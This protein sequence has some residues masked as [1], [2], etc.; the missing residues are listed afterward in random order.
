MRKMKKL[1]YCIFVG[2]ILL[3]G[4]KFLTSTHQDF[5]NGSVGEKIICFG[6]SLTHGTG[7][8]RGKD[9]PSQLSKMIS[10]PVINAGVPGDTTAGA[11][12]RLE[13]DVLSY[14]PDIVLITLGGNDLKNGVAS[15]AA[16]KNLKM[17]VNLIHNQGARVIIGGLSIPFRDRGFGRGYQKLADQTGA[18][19]IP[20]ILE[21]IMG[22]RKLLSDPIHPNDAG[23]K[24]MAE[25][26]YEAMLP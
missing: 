24:I 14:S 21:G 5:S 10:R 11:L 15:E 12:K 19:L 3:A 23:Y 9:Y 16:F 6:D 25:R 26:F 2:L 4:Y 22:N 17:I 1:I 8:S 7:A 13:R 18:T 20:N